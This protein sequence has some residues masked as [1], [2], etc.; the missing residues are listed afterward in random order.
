MKSNLSPLNFKFLVS[1]IMLKELYLENSFLF[2]LWFHILH[3]DLWLILSYIL[4]KRWGLGESFFFFCI[5]MT[6]YFNAICWK[7]YPFPIK[8]HWIFVK[9]QLTIFVWVYFWILSSISVIYVSTPIFD[10]YS[11][12]K[13]SLKW[14]VRFLL[15]YSF[16]PTLF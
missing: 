16:F 13:K 6:N 3:L 10:Y 7:D 8:L 2:V 4:Q 5:C 9:N 1:G 11:F 12:I 14:V 15:L